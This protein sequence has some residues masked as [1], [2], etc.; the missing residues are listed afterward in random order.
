MRL[1]PVAHAANQV[2][3]L[4]LGERVGAELADELVVAQVLAQR[5]VEVGL[6]RE[7]ALEEPL[8]RLLAE[9]EGLGGAGEVVLLELVED[10]QHDAGVVGYLSAHQTKSM[11]E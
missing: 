11:E 10:G 6:E 9:L 7:V 3:N 5:L 8:E 2:L 4:R 1:H